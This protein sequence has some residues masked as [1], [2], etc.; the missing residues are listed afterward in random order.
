M[1]PQKQARSLGL[2]FFALLLLSAGLASANGRFPHAQQLI[3]HPGDPNRLWIRATYGMLTSS[4]RG[5]NWYWVCE[6]SIGYRDLEDPSIAVTAGGRFLT[7]SIDG[8]SQT[9]D[10][11]CDFA[12]EQ[13]IG[14]QNVVDLSVDKVD[15]TRALAITSTGDGTGDY[16]NEVWRTTD[17][18]A[19]WARVG[20]RVDKTFLALTIDSAPSN[21]QIIY[22]TGS[23]FLPTDGGPE[24]A[25][26]GVLLRSSDGGSTWNSVDIPGTDNQSQP[27]LSAVDPADPKKLYI[28]VRGQDVSSPGEGQ[29]VENRLL[30][31]DNGGD[32]FREVLKG[33][34]DFL[35]FALAPD[36]K[37]VL[38]GMGDSRA[39][40]GTRPG[41]QVEYGLYQAT[42][43]ALSFQRVGHKNN[44]PVGH[45][46]C[47][48]FD[49]DTLWVCT[50]DITQ[51]FELARSTDRG[52]TLESVMQRKDLKGPLPCG[53]D[54][55]TGI[56]CP[57]QWQ[58]TC[59]KIG[60]CEVGVEDPVSCGGGSSGGG[61]A[62]G[63]SGSG[64]DASSGS[65]PGGSSGGTTAGTAGT[66]NAA[67]SGGSGSSCGCRIPAEE[68]G[69]GA[70]ASAALLG[71]LGSLLLF[72]RR[73]QG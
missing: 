71:A 28:R 72:V 34:A 18:A 41:N 36:G 21:A 4:D 26:K 55:K 23:I 35:G 42:A 31:S 70:G 33:N 39:L 52:L 8:L 62:G 40:G 22:M 60:R 13:S 67:G 58:L 12:F 47:L 29:F 44:T 14:Q 10:N 66:T 16:V 15:P 37:T 48:T 51:G 20:E 63:A 9:T 19:T 49:G 59:E 2:V 65:G 54:T 56:A 1:Y 50:S 11:G 57:E 61:G 69:F 73:R 3:V 30:Y 6:Q 43:P 17:S 27:Y 7:G 64:P 46:G 38:V 25:T 68:G 24:L 5:A 53:C 32:T 45:I